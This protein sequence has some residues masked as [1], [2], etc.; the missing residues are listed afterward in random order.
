MIWLLAKV[1]ELR[2]FASPLPQPLESKI[3]RVGESR[4]EH[5]Y[6]QSHQSNRCK[7]R[8]KRTKSYSPVPALIQE[9][10][11]VFGMIDKNQ[12][13][14]IACSNNPG[15]SIPMD[16]FLSVVFGGL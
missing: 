3:Q 16:F 7:R 8:W 6:A 15:L 10:L 5:I 11:S 14:K 12:E 13:K 1:H 9:Y 4:A 2:C